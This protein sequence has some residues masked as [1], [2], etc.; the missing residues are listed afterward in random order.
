M[1]RPTG[2]LVHKVDQDKLTAWLQAK[3]RDVHEM[4]EWEAYRA[5]HMVIVKR[6]NGKVGVICTEGV[7]W[8]ADDDGL[9]DVQAWYYGAPQWIGVPEADLVAMVSDETVELGEFIREHNARL[10]VNFAI[11]RDE[12]TGVEQDWS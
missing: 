12:I 9:L 11:W 4:T 3:A 1:S 2:Y 10:E 7:G 8:S 5:G 6:T